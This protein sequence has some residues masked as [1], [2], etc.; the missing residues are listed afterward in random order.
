MNAELQSI[1]ETLASTRTLL[2]GGP[3]KLDGCT[4]VGVEAASR[5]RFRLRAL[6]I[7]SCLRQ[8]LGDGKGDAVLS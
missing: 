6:L 7:P 5:R 4:R 8:E 1:A 3:F 2:M